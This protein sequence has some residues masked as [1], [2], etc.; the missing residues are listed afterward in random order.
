MRFKL[1]HG[2]AEPETPEYRAWRNMRS[3]CF[4]NRTTNYKNYGGREITICESWLKFKNFLKDMGLRPKGL[5]LDRIDNNGNYEPG[6]CHWVTRTQSNR[7]RRSVKLTLAAVQ[8]IQSLYTC[9]YTQT[10]IAR[11]FGVSQR[12]ISYIINGKRW[13]RDANPSP[14]D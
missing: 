5:M 14:G 6:N 3:R 10:E 11:K 8:E 12:H 7:N 9:G 2:H 13:K 4:N 1:I